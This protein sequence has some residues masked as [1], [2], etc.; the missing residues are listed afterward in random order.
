MAADTSNTTDSFRIWFFSSEFAGFK[1]RTTM[2]ASKVVAVWEEALS[3][4][5]RAARRPQAGALGEGYTCARIR[6]PSPCPLP[7]GEGVCLAFMK[8]F[9][10]YGRLRRSASIFFYRL[11]SAVTCRMRFSIFLGVSLDWY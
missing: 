9:Q 8:L 10:D 3:L 11:C 2:G 6:R 1:T 4:W 7:E 5:E